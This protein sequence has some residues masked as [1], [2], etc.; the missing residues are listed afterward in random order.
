[1]GQRLTVL[2]VSCIDDQ[3]V[4]AA[5]TGNELLA[6]DLV[7]NDHVG[8]SEIFRGAHG[9]QTWVTRTGADEGDTAWMIT[10]PGRCGLFSDGGVRGAHKARSVTDRSGREASGWM[11]SEGMMSAAPSLR[12]TA[13]S[14]LPRG[15]GSL[16]DPMR[17]RLRSMLASGLPA[18]ARR[19]SSV[20]FSPST[21]SARAPTGAVQPASREASR[22]RS[23]LTQARVSGSS[24]GDRASRDR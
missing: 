24:S 5:V 16:S 3:D 17:E 10:F 6:A 13:A 15:S 23:A 21:T 14:S 12:R 11:V 9:H 7:D 18:K 8:F 19:K 2:A 4:G 1:M 22:A 20:P